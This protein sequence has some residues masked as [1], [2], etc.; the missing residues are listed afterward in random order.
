MFFNF[1]SAIFVAGIYVWPENSPMYNVADVDLKQMLII[2]RVNCEQRIC[3]LCVLREIEDD[4]HV[5]IK[6]PAYSAVR[7]KIHFTL[8]FIE[9]LASLSMF[10]FYS[11]HILVL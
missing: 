6:C 1:D 4:F 5:V 9:D 2:N 8:F 10:L 3:T 7:N 11:H